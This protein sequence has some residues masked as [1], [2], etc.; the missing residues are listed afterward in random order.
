MVLFTLMVPTA[1]ILADKGLPR[2]TVT[3]AICVASVALAIPTFMVFSM[4]NLAL[5]WLM[6]AL[7][8]AM[9]GYA[10]GTLPAVMAAIYP[11]GVRVS[12]C[13]LGVNMSKYARAN[14][15][16]ETPSDPADYLTSA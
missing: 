8:L 4:H 9:S 3:L 14:R 6:Q 12:G 5:S 15:I 7:L 11:A 1:G 10:M 13:N 2:L 16:L